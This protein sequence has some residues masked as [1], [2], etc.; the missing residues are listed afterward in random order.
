MADLI[1]ELEKRFSEIQKELK[2]K[3]AL[4]DLDRVFHIKDFVLKEGY[5]SPYLSRII[6]YKITDTFISWNNW[7]H[8]LVMPFPNN[9]ISMAESDQFSDNEKQE[10]IRLMSKITAFTS[11]N[12]SINLIN[13][14]EKEAE[15]IDDSLKLWHNTVKPELIKLTKKLAAYWETQAKENPKKPNPMCL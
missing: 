3:S 7:L 6:C 13:D 2:F 1:S 14:P 8:S 12:L 4:D 9:M 5:V 10:I 15:F 11:R